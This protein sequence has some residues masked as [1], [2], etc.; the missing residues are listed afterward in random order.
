MFMAS[1]YIEHFLIKCMMTE[2]GFNL[3]DVWLNIPVIYVSIK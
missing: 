1:W 2:I 3:A